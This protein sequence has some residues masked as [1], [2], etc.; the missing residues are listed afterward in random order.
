LTSPPSALVGQ[1]LVLQ[2]ADQAQHLRHV[3]GGARLQRRR[4][5]AQ[6]ADV[7]LHGRDHLVGQ[8]RI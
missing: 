4:L 3:L 8:A 5:D 1:A 6:C 2:P 7:L